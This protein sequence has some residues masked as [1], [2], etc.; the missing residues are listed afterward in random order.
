MFS[1]K[2]AQKELIINIDPTSY[3]EAKKLCPKDY[4]L[5]SLEDFEDLYIRTYKE[6]DQEGATLTLV[7]KSTFI[8]IN[9][10]CKEFW[11]D[12][13]PIPYGLNSDFIYTIDMYVEELYRHSKGDEFTK[14]LTIYVKK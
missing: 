10:P 9:L 8:E 4:R 5:A 3:K 2:L 6:V 11:V 12:A 13:F 7:D 14:T 1:V